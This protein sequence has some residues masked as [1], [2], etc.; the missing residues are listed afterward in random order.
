MTGPVPKRTAERRRRNKPETP[1]TTVEIMAVAFDLP[2]PPP[3]TPDG[4]D[5]IARRWFESLKAS[6]QA[7]FYEP[8][9]WAQ[10]EVTAW[11]LS[12][13]VRMRRFSAPAF[14]AVIDS[15]G[16]LLTTEAD[17]RRVRME[18]DRKRDV[19]VPVVSELDEYRRRVYGS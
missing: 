9:D 13:V 17:R 11:A 16:G 14:K 12:K 4:L 15:M 7:Q 1:V 19:S 5:P 18:V 3:A 10:A 6:G 2:V 8:S